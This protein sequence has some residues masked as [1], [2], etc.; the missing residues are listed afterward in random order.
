MPLL[1]YRLRNPLLDVRWVVSPAVPLVVV[2]LVGVVWL[3]TGTLPRLQACILRLLRNLFAEISRN[4]RLV[5]VCPPKC[6]PQPV[7]A[8]VILVAGDRQLAVKGGVLI[9]VE[10]VPVLGVQRVK[11]TRQHQPST[12]LHPC[13]THQLVCDD[14]RC[15]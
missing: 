3:Q 7:S 10:V 12:R 13:N 15:L 2:T 8:T 6:M 11:C 9:C 5:V 4:L 14:L 1:S